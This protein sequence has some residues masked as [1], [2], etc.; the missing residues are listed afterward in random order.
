[1][2]LAT[3]VGGLLRQAEEAGLSSS[4][5]LPGKGFYAAEVIDLPQ[6]AGVPS[7]MPALQKAATRRLYDP[8]APVGFYDYGWK[9]ALKRYDAK[10]K[11]RR[12]RGALSVRVRGCVARHYK[13]GEAVAHATWGLWGWS[14][15]QVAREY[16]R[17][18]GIEASYRQLGQCLAAASSRGGR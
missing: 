9:G 11:E 6:R 4:R 7:L 13:R 3:A 10:A 8:R 18:F 14:P 17:R 1:M 16:R 12:G 5:L 15:A 2:R